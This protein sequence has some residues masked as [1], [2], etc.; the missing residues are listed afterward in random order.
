MFLCTQKTSLGIESN[1]CVNLEYHQMLKPIK[2]LNLSKKRKIKLIKDFEN[3]QNLTLRSVPRFYLLLSS[4]PLSLS[5]SPV[6]KKN[7][8]LSFSSAIAR[9]SIPKVL[10]VLPPSPYDDDDEPSHLLISSLISPYLL[11][12]S[13]SYLKQILDISRK[14]LVFK[15]KQKPG[16]IELSITTKDCKWNQEEQCIE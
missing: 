7:K 13:L 12:S 6:T 2:T 4:P 10:T 3:Q 14:T 5:L 1:D 9:P 8:N 11:S 16:R 15:I